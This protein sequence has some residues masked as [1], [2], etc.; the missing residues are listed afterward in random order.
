MQR[1]KPGTQWDWTLRRGHLELMCAVLWHSISSPLLSLRLRLCLWLY[2]LLAF[3]ISFMTKYQKC[4]PNILIILFFPYRTLIPSIKA[5]SSPRL[6]PTT[7]VP[8]RSLRSVLTRGSKKQL[9]SSQQWQHC[10]GDSFY[11]DQATPSRGNIPGLA[12]CTCFPHQIPHACSLKN[13]C[14]S[15]TDITQFPWPWTCSPFSEELPS[16]S[17]ETLSHTSSTSVVQQVG[18]MRNA[19]EWCYSSIVRDVALPSCQLPKHLVH[20]TYYPIPFHLSASG[21]FSIEDIDQSFPN[22]TYFNS[23]LQFF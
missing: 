23:Y 7:E 11:K 13:Q 17:F 3:Q 6:N 1:P 14:P 20:K 9:W 18:N 12:W 22:C 15:H 5:T 21:F 16:D 4:T 10:D 19:W 2:F 8:K